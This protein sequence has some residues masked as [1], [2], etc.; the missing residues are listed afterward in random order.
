MFKG[1]GQVASMLKNASQIQGR[2]QELQESLRRV[3]VQGLAGGGMV[4]VEMN[5]QQQVLACHIDPAVFA[6]G[7]REMIEDLLVGAFNQALDKVRQTTAEEMSKLAGG[8]DLSGLGE[9][10]SKLG[11]PEGVRE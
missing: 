10:L 8:F 4:S 9:T 1:I 5:G 7:D 6:S 3:R 11:G 2:M